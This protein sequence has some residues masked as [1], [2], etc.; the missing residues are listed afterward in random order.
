MNRK[1]AKSDRRIS[2]NMNNELYE[3]NYGYD[4]SSTFRNNNMTDENDIERKDSYIEQL[5]LK[6][7][8][9]DKVIS[10]LNNYKFLCEKRIKQ[11]NPGEKLPITLNSLKNEKSINSQ[12]INNNNSYNQNI[13]KKYELLN[14]KFEKLLNDYNEIISNNNVHDTSSNTINVGNNN[15]KYKL[16]KEKYKKLKTENKKIIELLK[17]ETK[18]CETQKNIIDVLQKAINNDILKNNNLKNYLTVENI[19]DFTQLKSEAEQYRKELVLSQALVNSLKSE[20][21]ILN[22]EKKEN[23]YNPENNQL[24]NNINSLN[25]NYN[26]N[27]NEDHNLIMSENLS[28]KSNLNSQAQLINELMEENKNLKKLVDEATIKLNDCISNRNENKINNENLNNELNTKIKEIKQ[29]EDKFIYFNEYITTIKLIF[30]NFQQSLPKFINIY[31]KLANED[32]NSLL[33][34]SFSQSIIKLNN[35][36]NQLNKIEKFNL[37]TNI[38]SDITNII[39]ELLHILNNEFISVYEKVFQT[40]CYYKESNVKIEEL[41]MQLRDNEAK[42]ENNLKKINDINDLLNNEKKNTKECQNEVEE[43][44]INLSISNIEKENLNKKIDYYIEDKNIIINSYY[45]IIKALSLYNESLSQLIRETVNI[46]ETKSK[47]FNEKEVIMEQLTKNKIK[48]INRNK[49]YQNNP[50]IN[51]MV[52]Q[53]QITLQNLINEFENKIKEKEEQLMLNQEKINQCVLELQNRPIF[54]KNKNGINIDYNYNYNYYIKN[55]ENNG[56]N[57][58]LENMNNNNLTPRNNPDNINNNYN[59]VNKNGVNFTY[60]L[61]NK[62]IPIDNK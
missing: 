33:S 48:D 11:L 23:N 7:E 1:N 10:D 9:Q 14:E 35:R 61:I 4:V 36:I 20:I 12:N 29:Y 19:I 45:L 32:L 58:H 15:D 55:E 52:T 38:E 18:A 22:K 30:M 54:S 8:E 37:E 46:I 26:N 16:L 28:L 40:N 13:N 53:E 3:E 47:L 59:N 24:N 31:N 39:I 56:N 62:N 17:E 42:N 25:N 21:E 27:R 50:D 34:N 51:K 44:K 57:N 49:T 41:K 60:A 6:I 5:Q 43:Y 2:N